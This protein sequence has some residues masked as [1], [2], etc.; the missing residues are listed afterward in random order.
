VA[1]Q[2]LQKSGSHAFRRDQVGQL[3]SVIDR[4]EDRRAGESAG[5][6]RENAFGS[7]ALV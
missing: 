5:D 2:V 1:R 3:A 7:A 6:V 4:R